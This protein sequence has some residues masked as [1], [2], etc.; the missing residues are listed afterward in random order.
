MWRDL[1]PGSMQAELLGKTVG[2]QVK[3][4]LEPGQFFAPFSEKLLRAVKREQFSLPSG[5]TK[6]DKHPLRG[7]FYPQCYLH[8]VPGVFATSNAP[9]RFLGEQGEK[10]L[11]DLN[12]PLAGHSL[13]V[14]ATIENI[15]QTQVER[16][17]RCEDWLEVLSAD[18]PGMQKSLTENAGT[19]LQKE[20]FHRTD[21]RADTLFYQAPRLVQHLDSTARRLIGAEYAHLL[22]GQAEVLDLMGSWDSHLPNSCSIKALTVLGLNC[23][24]LQK[25]GRSNAFV[26]HDVNTKQQLPFADG[27]FDAIISTASIEY[28]IDLPRLFREASR[29][30]R[31]KG[32]LAVS[33]SN[34]WFPSKTIAIWSQLHEFER[35]ALVLQMF[36]SA[37]GFQDFATLSI[38]GYPRPDDD[39]HSLALAD[40]VYMVTA[41]K[42]Y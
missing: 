33:F 17:G 1:F 38:R 37:E 13:T 31:P 12:H 25:N 30:L 39:P 22:P 18:G 8:D 27:S 32:T 7:R 9:C 29:I 15:E 2:D 35:L 42:I 41:R 24:E 19:F 3:V 10:L 4:V 40:P 26:V 11:F 23:E 36:A 28:A 14:S 6:T 5:T 16:G 21:E 34:R 20:S